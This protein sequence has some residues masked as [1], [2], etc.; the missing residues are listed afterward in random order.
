M[1]A[2]EIAERLMKEVRRPFEL[3]RVP[4]RKVSVTAGIGIAVGVRHIS[5]EMLRDTDVAL[6]RAEAKG[7]ECPSS[8]QRMW[9]R[10]SAGQSHQGRSGPT[11]PMRRR[12]G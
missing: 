10:P 8:P 3:S 9:S 12:T 2:D 6:S 5:D 11:C 4:G 1:E 7:K